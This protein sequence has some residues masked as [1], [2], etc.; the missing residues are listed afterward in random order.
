MRGAWSALLVVLLA[1]SAFPVSGAA[2]PTALAIGAPPALTVVTGTTDI[3]GTSAYVDQNGDGYVVIA[4]IDTGINPYNPDFALAVG[5]PA[6]HP[7]T[8]IQG[9]P[10]AMPALP[11]TCT[12]T[13]NIGGALPGGA[14]L[15]DFAAV[16]TGTAYWIPNTKI[17]AAITLG[18]GD[19]HTKIL[20]DYDSAA[21]GHG[22]KST[23]V[24]VG[25]IRGNC[26]MCLA[27]VIEGLGDA[28]LNW[29][30]T[31]PWID[32]VSNSWGTQYNAGTPIIG[33]ANANTK[34][35]T[36]NGGSVLFAAGNGFENAFVT[37][38]PTYQSPYAGPDWHLVVGAIDEST[39]TS[40]MGSGK[41]VQ[42]SS[43]GVGNI[44]AACEGTLLT[45]CQHSGT[46]AATPQV[47]GVM[48]QI[49]LEAKKMLGDTTEGPEGIVAGVGLAAV[50]NPVV[51]NQY[52]SDGKLSRAELWNIVLRTAHPLS[53]IPLGYPVVGGPASP[54]D[55]AYAG[56]G[57][58]NAAS[59]DDALLVLQCG[60]DLPDT[61]ERDDF[62]A[63]DSNLRRQFW[64]AWSES[65]MG[66][67][68]G[69]GG[70]P[71][72][73][74]GPPPPVLP[75]IT[76]TVN[77]APA[78]SVVPN[79]DGTWLKAINFGIY[80]LD[81]NGQW[82]VVAT[83]GTLTDSRP[84]LPPPV[85]TPPPSPAA[86]G[87]SRESPSPPPPVPQDQTAPPPPD[88]DFD[89]VTN[90]NCPNHPN[91]NQADLDGDGE[92]D[93]CDDD[94]DN[95]GVKDPVDN[96]P[97]V[98]NPRENGVQ[99]DDDGD[100]DGDACDGIDD[101]LSP[102]LEERVDATL[103]AA[104]ARSSPAG[105]VPATSDHLTGGWLALGLVAALAI[106]L[107]VVVVVGLRK[108]A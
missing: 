44:P 22:T 49:L 56:Y 41:P 50:G 34:T 68:I 92:G 42:V 28:Q 65:K 102:T 106:L 93:V 88:P 55:Y 17:V 60:N 67:G 51:G 6:G 43:Y 31:Q 86:S 61:T 47:A 36:Q 13:T 52:L 85:T 98:Y 95:D 27:V 18:G 4:F 45:D 89:G 3:T 72:G 59:R 74:T 91:A 66:T 54:V 5:Q 81:S 70:S 73:C 40:V 101:R 14:C 100:G 39:E 33:T 63:E 21:W 53:D 87:S 99:A 29:A 8:Y 97:R 1:A 80:A 62:I 48:G 76:F 7:S 79:P 12:A 82:V 104:P 77:G 32:I 19:G 103:L 78:G 84:Y 69:T 57:I 107:L 90:D 105:D 20:D 46:S 30:A 15:S 37:P 24:S 23:S 108:K 35:M 10:A 2:V 83:Y 11:L 71:G 94:D 64:G 96:C 26:P 16:V 58:V 25:N 38:Q 75:S 9:F